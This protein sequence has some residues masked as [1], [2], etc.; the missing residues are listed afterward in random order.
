[1][2]DAGSLRSA[3][4]SYGQQNSYPCC[5]VLRPVKGRAGLCRQFR[6]SSLQGV[7]VKISTL[8]LSNRSLQARPG[9]VQCFAQAD[10]LEERGADDQLLPR[11]SFADSFTLGELLGIGSF[12]KVYRAVSKAQPGQDFAV[13]IVPKHREGVL[14][15]RI[16]RRIHEEIE[17]LKMLQSRP[18]AVQLV[19]VFEDKDQVCIVTE[20]CL[21]GD[22]EHFL[23]DYGSMTEAE[24]A[25]AAHDILQVLAECHRQGICYAD[26]KP[27][28]FLLKRPYSRQAHSSSDSSAPSRV[29]EIR[30]G[31]FGCSQRLQKKEKL[32]KRTGTPLYMA[33]ELFMR[34]YGVESDQ[35][36]LGIMMYQLLSGHLPFWDEQSDRSPF[37]V[38]SA[39][40]SKEVCYT[41]PEW[42]GISDSAKNF[43]ASLLDRDYN[44]RMTAAEALEHPWITAHCNEDGCSVANNVVQLKGRNLRLSKNH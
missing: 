11:D 25:H 43:V 37:A 1:M 24:A 2:T 42:E 19:G 13:K 9:Q 22:L 33:P 5:H 14:D 20:L 29:L 41:G 10:K 16:A 28:N 23:K 30:V 12:G 40:L 7:S 44:S 6:V 34:Y 3:R 8:A 21:G 26:V 18:E 39:I 17:T 36:A 31:D 32:N 38:M 4:A 35:W 15:E 27:A